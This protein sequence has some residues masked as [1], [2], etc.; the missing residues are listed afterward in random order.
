MES[1]DKN[2]KYSFRNLLYITELG[3]STLNKMIL[4]QLILNL[5][6]ASK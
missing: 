2:A 4:S 5:R 6:K 1:I 3:M